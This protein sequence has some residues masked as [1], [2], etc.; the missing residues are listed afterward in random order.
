VN[1][2]LR[3]VGRTVDINKPYTPTLR[4][5]DKSVKITDI[6][7]HTAKL[8]EYEMP[9]QKQEI[10]ESAKSIATDII[11]AGINGH[12]VVNGNEILIMDTDNK[13]TA[14]NV[15]R[16]NLGGWG[17]S[18]NG[19]NGPF[20]MAA[21]LDGGFVADFIT[22]GVLRGLEIV[23]GNGTFHVYPD[24]SVDAA[25]LNITGGKID[26]ITDS[27]NSFYIAIQNPSNSMLLQSG[28]LRIIDSTD[29]GII[30]H[31]H[32]LDCYSELIPGG[33]SELSI[34]LHSDTGVAEVK[35]LLF[36]KDNNGT[37]Y[38]LSGLINNIITRLEN[39]EGNS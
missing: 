22:A 20:T 29:C 3:L 10:L 6:A 33:N 34:R 14:R 36:D 9:K 15:W 31:G 37:Q 26:M 5:G 18:H 4:I 12:V 30:A 27:I 8:I 11:N 35:N 1:E 7:T 16:Y 28:M 21:T 24:G 13:D 19:Y 38:S 23:N 2:A 32:G 25:S 17:V 39:L